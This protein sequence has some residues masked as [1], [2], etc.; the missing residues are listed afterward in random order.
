MSEMAAEAEG[1]LDGTKRR[2]AIKLGEAV[3]ELSYD[4]ETKD[5][6]EAGAV[7]MTMAPQL[8]VEVD[9]SFDEMAE[10]DALDTEDKDFLLQIVDNPHSDYDDQLE[11]YPNYNTLASDDRGN[12]V[13]EITFQDTDEPAETIKAQWA[14]IYLG[15]ERSVESD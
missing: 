10:E 13:L 4:S 3:L 7:L 8:L 5:G 9:G 12:R 1:W 11:G 2:M 15:G 14:L 6:A